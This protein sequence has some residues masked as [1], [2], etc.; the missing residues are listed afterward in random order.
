MFY[1]A[2][3]C[4]ESEKKFRESVP[5][6][7]L[8]QSLKRYGSTK[9]FSIVVLEGIHRL[10]DNYLQRLKACGF[11]II[12]YSEPF[13]EIIKTFR[14]IDRFYTPDERNWLLRWIAFKQIYFKEMDEHSQ[15]WH[16]DS[17]VILHTSLDELAADTKGKTFMLQGCPVLVSVSNANWFEVYEKELK[18]LNA[19]IAG[20]SN[21]AALLKEQGK[22]NDMVLSNQSLY[23][24]PIGHDQD[25]LEYLVSSGKIIQDTSAEIYSS[26]YYFIQN[27]LSIGVWHSLQS[28]NGSQFQERDDRTI[29][30]GRKRVPFIHYQNDFSSFAEIYMI[31]DKNIM[32]EKLKR[33]ILY[34]RI[35]DERF[36]ASLLYRIIHKLIKKT[37]L[38]AGREKV[39]KKLMEGRGKTKLAGLLNFVN[40]TYPLNTS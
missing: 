21:K 6:E 26:K 34:Y 10:S 4:R 36:E 22:K 19:D 24:N 13:K 39:I 27:I 29:E 35:K 38:S 30:I 37:G 7:L 2:I 14:N 5:L 12:D 1:T 25:L 32:P 23:R 20:Y 9:K 11:T 40:K 31:L 15:F 8:G 28:E 3:W 16:L 18:E 33:K 17:D